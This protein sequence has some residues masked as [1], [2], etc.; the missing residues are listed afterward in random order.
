VAAETAAAAAKGWAAHRQN[1][2]ASVSPLCYNS[3][4]PII[5]SSTFYSLLGY[6][7]PH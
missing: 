4:K 7:S 5:A 3:W 6:L 1:P 2:E